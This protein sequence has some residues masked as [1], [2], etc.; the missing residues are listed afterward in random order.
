MTKA[1]SAIQPRRIA[2][3]FADDIKP[4]FKEGEREWCH[5]FNGVSLT[6]PYLEPFLIDTMREAAEHITD[7]LVRADAQAFNQ[8]ES[9]H[10]RQHRRYNEILKQTYP[11]LARIEEE[12][13]K[14]YARLR[15]RSLRSRL[16][17]TAGFE[18]MTLGL[19][20]WLITDR[21]R[22]FKGA[23]ERVVSFILWHM[24]EE[25][26]HKRAAY[27]VY[28]HVCPGY[29]S[30]AL[31]VFRG[32]LHV[33]YYS[34][35]AYIAMLRADGKWYNLVSRLR[36]WH[37]ILIFYRYVGPYLL[38]AALPGH[39]PDRETDPPWVSEWIAN[40]PKLAEGEIPMLDTS[41][42]DIPP[43]LGTA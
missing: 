8:Q 12:M 34:R 25:T 10:Y 23:D 41:H 28:Q 16:A 11:E 14:G 4:V 17:Y 1:K 26:E 13:E 31:G 20:R 7:P 21:R 33:M 3:P 15:K 2:F 24:V 22:L 30:R 18:S 35:R 5:M 38:R 29:F 37:R 6:M 9:Q 32:S 19:T 40:Y 36:L 43:P 39:T 27:S 42:P